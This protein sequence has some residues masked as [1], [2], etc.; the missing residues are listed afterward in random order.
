MK[1]S[2]TVAVLAMVAV[3]IIGTVG[4]AYA[5][6]GPPEENPG[7]GGSQGQGKRHGFFGN[8]TEVIEVGGN[9]TVALDTKEGW[10][11][12]LALTDETRY[13]VPS[14]TKGRVG[15]EEFVVALGGNLTALEGRRIAVL[16]TGVVEELGGVFDGEAQRLMV[17]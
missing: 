14:V 4:A 6:G 9:V 2:R 1:Y 11:V 3:L 16:A 10:T 5:K 8:V 13:M 12:N 17:I 7:R 15:F